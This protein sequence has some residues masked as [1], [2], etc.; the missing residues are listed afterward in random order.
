MYRLAKILKSNGTS[1][2][3]LVSAPEVDLAEIS[4]PVFIEFDGLPVPFF[5]EQCTP[6]GGKYIVHLTDIDSLQDAEEVVGS[7]ILSE[8]NEEQFGSDDAE[9]DF[10]GWKVFDGRHYIGKVSGIAPIPGNCCLYIERE[11]KE[12]IMIPLHPDFISEIHEEQEE[13]RLN[14]PEGLY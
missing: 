1:G 3:L 14:L 2:D 7:Y 6:K 8:N 9:P 11:D 5:I 12:E 13:L 4:G 10:C